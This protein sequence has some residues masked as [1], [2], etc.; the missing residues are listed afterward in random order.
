MLSI[1]TAMTRHGDTQESD[2][3][4]QRLYALDGEN[5]SGALEHVNL[6]LRDADGTLCGGLLGQQYWN[7]MFIDILWIEPRFRGMGY[8]RRLMSEIEAIARARGLDL[9]HLD[10]QGLEVPGFYT[11]LGF[12]M[13]GVLDDTPR[14]YQRYFM[15]KR[16]TKP[17]PSC[18]RR[19]AGS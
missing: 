17:D 8:G 12:E 4:R 18:S 6:Y 19:P 9:L 7:C 14:G 15:V 1:E 2:Y 13:F 3:V 16:L 5:T 11:K 10:A